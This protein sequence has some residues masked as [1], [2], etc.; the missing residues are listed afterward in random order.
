M[1]VECGYTP[2]RQRLTD[3]QVQAAGES[4]ADRIDVAREFR[5]SLP[6]EHSEANG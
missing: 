5:A 1:P 4:A 3:M 6:G 2:D